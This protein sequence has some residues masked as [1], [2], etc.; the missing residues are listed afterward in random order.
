MF[1]VRVSVDEVSAAHALVGY[2]G[3]CARLH[4]HN[5][6]FAA[7]I[8]AE[9]LHQD[10]VVDFRLIK[11]VFRSLDHSNLNDIPD[12]QNNGIRPTAERLAVYVAEQIERVLAPLPNAPHLVSVTVGETSRNQVTYEPTRPHGEEWAP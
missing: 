7:V 10:M 5:W 11:N 2:P 12:F 3:E 4:G 9:Q 6:S 1:T 8:A